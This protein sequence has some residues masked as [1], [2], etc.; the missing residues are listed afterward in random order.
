MEE[1]AARVKIL[2]KERGI[3]NRKLTL[4]AQFLESYN[5]EPQYPSLAKY[6]AE[7]DESR[8]SLKKV[9][10]ESEDLGE[11]ILTDKGLNDEARNEFDK[12]YFEIYNSA[13]NLLG[14]YARI[15]AVSVS[16]ALSENNGIIP[17]QNGISIENPVP[18]E[19]SDN[20]KLPS[21]GLPSFSGS[22]DTWLGF[23]EVFSSMIDNNA[24]LS[25]ILKFRYLRDCLKGEAADVIASVTLSAENYSVAWEIV[26]VTYNNRKLI[27][28]R[29]IQDL[30]NIPSISKD[31]SIRALLNSLQ[32]HVR[33]LKILDESFLLYPSY[34]INTK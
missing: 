2:K 17:I 1:I 22:Y 26:K 28:Q 33:A 6:A 30:L 16:S 34:C 32:K 13:T 3:I 19:H 31:F 15:S 11:G 12:K 7:L 23:H 4:F 25:P 29:H 9:Q 8:E 21:L 18:K 24:K 14:N 5:S 10:F 27:H 20:F